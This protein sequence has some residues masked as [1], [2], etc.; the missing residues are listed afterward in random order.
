VENRMTECEGKS[1][2]SNEE[3]ETDQAMNALALLF[4][5][6]EVKAKA[7]HRCGISGPTEV[8]V[9]IEVA[10][11]DVFGRN[12]NSDYKRWIRRLYRLG[13][14]SHMPDDWKRT[15]N[16]GERANASR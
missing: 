2:P 7:H 6:P 3:S 8:E 10:L 5:S 13:L 1:R 16:C 12:P 9:V 4:S 15:T 14:I 11:D